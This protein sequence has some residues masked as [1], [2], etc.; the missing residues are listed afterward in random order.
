[1]TRELAEQAARRAY[2]ADKFRR[3]KRILLIG[4]DFELVVPRVP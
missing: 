3:I 2:G 4:S 1:M